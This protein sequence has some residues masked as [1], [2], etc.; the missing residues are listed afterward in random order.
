MERMVKP[1]QQNSPAPVA[2]AQQKQRNGDP[3]SVRKKECPPSAGVKSRCGSR[4]AHPEVESRSKTLSTAQLL[5]TRRCPSGGA[6]MGIEKVR[7]GK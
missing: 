1:R 2:S 7:G 4:S 6:K 3:E 5:P